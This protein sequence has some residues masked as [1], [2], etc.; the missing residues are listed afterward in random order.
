MINLDYGTKKYIYIKKQNPNM[1][2]I[3]D[4][5]N[6]KTNAL[7]NLISSHPDIDKIYSFSKD[8]KGSRIGIIN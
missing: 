2:Q 7:L 5:P 1:L 6:R 3:P 8:P 4:H